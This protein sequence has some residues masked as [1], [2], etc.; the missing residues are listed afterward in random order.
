MSSDRLGSEASFV[1]LVVRF[2]YSCCV[3][4][5]SHRVDGSSERCLWLHCEIL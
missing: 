1:V 2:R 5:A 3:I 4:R